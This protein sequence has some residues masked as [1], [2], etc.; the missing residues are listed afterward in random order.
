MAAIL[1][2]APAGKK[3]EQLLE[4]EIENAFKERG[5]R[6]QMQLWEAENMVK[7]NRAQDAIDYLI[8]H[9]NSQTESFIKEF[10]LKD[11]ISEPF[12]H[13]ENLSQIKKQGGRLMRQGDRIIEVPFE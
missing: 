6:E 11:L 12:V 13:F 10:N 5:L 2:G 4:K 7:N 3:A 9:N 8:K 1:P